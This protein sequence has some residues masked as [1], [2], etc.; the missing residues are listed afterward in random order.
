MTTSTRSSVR[1]SDKTQKAK[2]KFRLVFDTLCQDKE[3]QDEYGHQKPHDFS[4][5]DEW[6]TIEWPFYWRKDMAK[7]YI[8]HTLIQSIVIGYPTPF[9]TSVLTRFDLC[10]E[11]VD[12]IVEKCKMHML[13]KHMNVYSEENRTRDDD[14]GERPGHAWAID[15]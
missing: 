1:K 11:S 14:D 6:A 15:K 2:T 7:F 5:A 12:E 4:F 13:K 3:L 8:D 9:K 10:N